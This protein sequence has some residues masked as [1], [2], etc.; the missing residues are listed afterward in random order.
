[1]Q[2]NDEMM[3][4]AAT[5]AFFGGDKPIHSST[6]YRGIA[7]GRYPRPVRIG[8]NTARWLKSECQKA[9]QA[10]IEARDDELAK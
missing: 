3:T 8:P 1:M 2:G 6:L 10:L 7:A 5:C 9:V 4:Q